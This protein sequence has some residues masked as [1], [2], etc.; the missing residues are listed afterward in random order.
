MG[1]IVH[2]VPLHRTGINPIKDINYLW[3]LYHLLRN[4]KPCT[5]LT[6]TIKPNI[7]GTVAGRLNNI[8]SVSM[9]TGL[10]YSFIP[11]RS[12]SWR[13][14]MVQWVAMK[15][16]RLGTNC[17]QRV[18]FQNPDDLRDFIKAGCLVDV[19]KAQIVN[20]SGV[21]LKHYAPTPLPPQPV[22]L[23]ISRLL[24]NK[25][26]R[27]YGQASVHI[28]KMNPKARCLLV[29][30]FEPGP[31]GISQL[32]LDDWTAGGL[33]YLGPQK[34]VRPFIS[35]ASI[36]VLPSYREGTPRSVLE[37]MAMGRAIITTDA[38]GCRATTEHE[39]N[40]L[41]VPIKDVPALSNAMQR[42]IDQPDTRTEMGK[43]SLAQVREKYDANVVSTDIIRHL[44]AVQ[45]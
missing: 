27:E 12:R 39:K 5:V 9:V 7:W 40:G 21:D 18:I 6:Y 35:E 23:M 13:R 24:R 45:C 3:R 32:E 26:V 22:F 38:P 33:E 19:D 20:G 36:Y 25:G 17:S 8:P 31:D 34:D 42:L 16:Y 37:A 2:D 29:G 43:Q 41:L 15:L 10:G 30:Y 1:V 28:K 14:S 11:A 4:I 44:K